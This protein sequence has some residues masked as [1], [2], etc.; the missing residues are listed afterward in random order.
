VYGG[1]GEVDH[2]FLH[3]AR[4]LRDDRFDGFAVQVVGRLGRRGQRRRL[5]MVGLAAEH[6]LEEHGIGGSEGH[7]A[8]ALADQ[9]GSG[10]AARAAGFRRHGRR[11]VVVA[12]GGDLGQ[13]VVDR[14]EVVSRGGVRDL[15]PTRAFAQGEAA[16]TL[17]LQQLAPRRDQRLAQLAVMI[18]LLGLCPRHG[19]SAHAPILLSRNQ[20]ETCHCQD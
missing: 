6:E 9:A 8:H 4:G 14:G 11:E 12:A 2:A 10:I 18:G 3:V 15:R 17:L 16:Q 13:Q 1:P 5:E 19:P 20:A 7:V